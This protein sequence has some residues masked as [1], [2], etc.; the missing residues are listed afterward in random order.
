MEIKVNRYDH[1]RKAGDEKDLKQHHRL[2]NWDIST[3]GHTNVRE[4]GTGGGYAPLCTRQ[5][6]HLQVWSQA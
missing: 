1:E 5:C 4:A 3:K 2:L 6:T